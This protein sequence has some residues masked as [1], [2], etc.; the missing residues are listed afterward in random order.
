MDKIIFIWLHQW[1]GQN[2]FFDQ[3]I[4][5]LSQY[6]TYLVI[7]AIFLTCIFSFRRRLLG[8]LWFDLILFTSGIA[9]FLASLLKYNLV[10][11]RPF[12]FWSSVHP[13]FLAGSLESFPSGHA[14]FFGALAGGLLVL[15][16]RAG[17]LALLAALIIGLARVIAGVHWPSDIVSGLIF[18]ALAGYWQV[19]LVHQLKAGVE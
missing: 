14:V 6:F 9:W 11:P 16:R 18:G 2:W 8:L 4:L 7:L 5:F 10:S 12:I 3:L 17:L 13:L 15:N 19:S 1:A